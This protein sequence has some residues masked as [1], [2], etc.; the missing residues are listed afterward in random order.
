[1]NY[2]KIY[3]QLIQR[4]I[5]DNRIKSSEIYY[6][7]H[8]IIPRC[9]NGDNSADN[10]VLLTAREHFIAHWLLYKIY[11][12]DSLAHAWFS[13]TRISSDQ[14]RY[15]S[16]SFEYAKI[17]HANAVRNFFTNR[18]LSV[19]QLERLIHNNPNRK[20]TVIDNRIFNSKKS[21]AE[22][23][24]VSIS[25][26]NKYIR[27]E[28][29]SQYLYDSEYRS[30]VISQNISNALKNSGRNKGKTYEEIY[31][32][33]K[34]NKIKEQQNKNRTYK[35]HSQETKKKISESKVG[36]PS[37]HAG[38]KRNEETKKKLSNIRKGDSRSSKSYKIIDPS[39]KEYIV[40]KKGL[41]YFWM[42]I[43]KKDFPSFFK[44]VSTFKECIKGEWKGWKVYVL[45]DKNS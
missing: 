10:L 40:I 39:G 33:E 9:M 25:V 29:T 8:H 4:A 12:T 23:Y 3:D 21:A 24:N 16:R 38:K 2:S 15:T 32:E 19:K 35:E 20:Q 6:E 37:W 7:N 13:M 28:I 42:Q 26:I 31:G 44:K 1:M 36:K 14:P 18:K 30:R 17:A 27:D 41:P 11:N 5:A 22:F 34:A 45:D 43:L